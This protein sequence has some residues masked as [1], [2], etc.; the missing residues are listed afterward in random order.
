MQR[1]IQFQPSGNADSREGLLAM[2]LNGNV[3]LVNAGIDIFDLKPA[4][5]I[6]AH[7][8]AWDRIGI[9]IHAIATPLTL[10]TPHSYKDMTPI[11]KVF[12]EYQMMVVRTQSL[13]E[14]A[15]VPSNEGLV[16]NLDTSVVFHLNPGRAADV[17]EKLGNHYIDAI[18]EPTVRSAVRDSTASH[19]AN[20]LYSSA[21][22]EVQDQ[23]RGTLQ[24]PMPL[25]FSASSPRPCTISA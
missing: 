3:D 5:V 4:L 19:S 2:A 18:I 1:R 23:I 8:V 11:A 15:A 12:S 21:R 9:A 25:P 14:S 24:T 20:A 16:M 10:G 17:Y 13:K 7:R 6:A 22:Q